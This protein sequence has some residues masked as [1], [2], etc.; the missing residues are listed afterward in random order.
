MNIDTHG[1]KTLLCALLELTVQ[2]IQNTTKYQSKNRRLDQMVAKR[3]ALHW[4]RSDDFEM[5]CDA[6]GVPPS[7]IR[8]AAFR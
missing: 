4:I 5:T 1:A 2:D 3:E 6:V 8:K 7:L